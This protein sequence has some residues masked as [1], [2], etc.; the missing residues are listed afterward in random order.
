MYSNIPDVEI[1]A[2][3]DINQTELSSVA[4][5]FAIKNTYHD[6]RMLLERHDLDAVDICLHNNLHAP[7]TI[8]CLKSGKNVYC[9]KPLAGSYADAKAMLE[10]A[11]FYGKKLHIQLSRIYSPQCKMARQ[12]IDG[13]ALGHI[14][15]ARSTGFRRRSRPF[16]DGYG[17]AA[18]VQKDKSGGGAL[19]DSGIYNISQLLYL[20]D[21]PKTLRISGKIYQETAMD[22]NRSRESAYD[23][24]EI[25]MGFIRFEGGLTMDVIEA[26]AIHLNNLEPSCI[27]GSKAGIKIDPFSYH[28]TFNDLEMDSTFDIDKITTRWNSTRQDAVAYHS[29]QEHWVAAL[30]G[31]VALLPTAE[32]ALQTMLIQEGIYISDRLNREVDAEEVIKNSVSTAVKL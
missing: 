31:K 24:E 10:A 30:Q 29:S 11:Q 23:V 18:F 28:T 16:V 3:A 19:Y 4:E 17:T 14:Y 26:W 27:L 12:L 13:G 7:V 25:A 32:L 2:A 21:L 9:E 22:E 5:K 20:L 6:F 1:V 8:E 15:H